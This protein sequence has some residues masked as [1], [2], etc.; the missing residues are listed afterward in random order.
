VYH[1]LVVHQES[2][3]IDD[4]RVTQSCMHRRLHLQKRQ[5]FKV[6][7]RPRFEIQNQKREREREIE[8]D[9]LP[10]SCAPEALSLVLVCTAALPWGGG[11]VAELERPAVLPSL[12]RSLNSEAN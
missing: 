5:Y 8:E 10:A 7:I 2:I 4:N 9:F 11:T 12:Y 6:L 3:E 1:L